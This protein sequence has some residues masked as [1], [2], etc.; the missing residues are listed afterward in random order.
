MITVTGLHALINHLG[1]KFTT[2]LTDLSGYLILAGTVV[3]TAVLFYSSPT[4]D[5][6]RLWTFTNYCYSMGSRAERLAFI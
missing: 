5:F 3:L 1:I 6:S 2:R 4:H